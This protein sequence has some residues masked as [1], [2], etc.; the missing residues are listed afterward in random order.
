MTTYADTFEKI[1]EDFLQRNI[2]IDVPGF[3]DHKNFLA[4]EQNNPEYLN[5]YARFVHD[6]PRTDDYNQLVKS[7]VPIIA[8]AF[9]EKLKENGRLGACV[10]ISGVISRALESEGIFNFVV[11]G[12]LT[13]DFPKKSTITRKYFWSV[14]RGDFTAAHAWVVAPPFYIVDVSVQLQPYTD[15]EAKY[16]PNLICSEG[17]IGPSGLLEDIV[18]PELLAYAIRMG[19]PTAK[20]LDQVSPGTSK[21][22]KVFPA[23]S[24][25]HESTALKYVPVAVTAP[26]LPFLEMVAIKFK[27]KTGYEI[28]EEEIKQALNDH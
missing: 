19:V 9:H 28:Y 3:Y 18:A 2:P 11:K 24:E 21:F 10:D 17:P 16:L 8:D 20:I 23:R 1:K 12:S 25:K 26:D 6:R 14:D 7:K 15:G 27:G 5:N 22:I 13:I 4:V